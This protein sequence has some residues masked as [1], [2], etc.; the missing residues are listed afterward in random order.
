MLK[1]SETSRYAARRTHRTYTRE[2]K[3]ELMA[4][5]QVPGVSIAAVAGAHA[6]NANVLHR[7]LKEHAS[8]GCHRQHTIE[9]NAGRSLVDLPSKLPA[10]IPVQLPTPDPAPASVAHDIKTLLLAHL[11]V[12]VPGSALCKALH[13]LSSQWP[14]LVRYVQD[15]RYPIDNNACENSIRPFVVGR[16]GWLF[17]DTAAGANASANLYSPWCRHARPT[18][19][20]PIATCAPCSSHC[21]TPG[22]LTTTRQCCPGASRCR[23]SEHRPCG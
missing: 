4:A 23:H 18:A 21:P 17:S 19:S 20:T 6:M 12:V 2:F 1:D 8:S 11:H 9:G 15:G 7:W 5:C 16:T 13:Y 22:R 10:F 3:A 14:K